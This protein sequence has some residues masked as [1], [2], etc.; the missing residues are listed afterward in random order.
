MPAFALRLTYAYAH[1]QPAPASRAPEEP[2]QASCSSS[3]STSAPSVVPNASE[4]AAAGEDSADVDDQAKPRRTV[5][6]KIP[7]KTL[8][9]EG[10]DKP[11]SSPKKGK[12]TKKAPAAAEEV[13][14]VCH[15]DDRPDE[16]LLC[17][18]KGP[19]NKQCPNAVHLKCHEPP[20]KKIPD[21]E[22]YCGECLDDDQ[23]MIFICVH[24]ISFI[25][26]IFLPRMFTTLLRTCAM[27]LS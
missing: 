19:G 13:C 21:G 26:M 11:V 18:G 10:I 12:S 6:P 20:L 27:C 4:P 23:G 17:D 5:R 22:W 2:V 16:L 14:G 8:R 25:I 24:V 7:R 15:V 9:V 1:R 3:S